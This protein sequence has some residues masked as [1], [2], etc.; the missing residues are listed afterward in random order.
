MTLECFGDKKTS[1]DTSLSEEEMRRLA[2]HE[3]GHVYIALA[4]GVKLK[5]VTLKA[6]EV[7]LGHTTFTF[8]KKLYTPSDKDNYM[9]ILLGGYC[10]EM[11]FL[12][13]PSILS[14]S[15]L[16]K[17]RDVALSK[18]AKFAFDGKP[19]RWIV[20]KNS[21]EALKKERED[22]IYKDVDE[23]TERAKKL[24]KEHEEEIG[25][26]ASTLCKEIELEGKRLYK[27]INKL[28]Q[29]YKKK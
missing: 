27:E 26:F 24:I 15:D 25:E 11:L 29:K 2:L 12:K 3:T 5:K 20:N 16:A 4:L 10:A 17:V 1:N 28:K 6:N 18:G 21:S 14:S 19:A 9:S 8:G 23:C 22:I 7:L 13:E